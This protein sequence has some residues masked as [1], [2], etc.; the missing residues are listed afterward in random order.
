M[1]FDVLFG[2]RKGSGTPPPPKTIL[3]GEGCFP[4]FLFLVVAGVYAYHN[5]HIFSPFTNSRWIKQLP[6]HLAKR[7]KIDNHP[8][9]FLPSKL[10]P[11]QNHVEKSVGVS[12]V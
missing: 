6:K 8:G 5:T 12:Q 2:G 10:Y 1:F 7:K 11:R 3:E 9:T 4:F